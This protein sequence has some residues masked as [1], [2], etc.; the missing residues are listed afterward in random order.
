MY[1]IQGVLNLTFPHR[2]AL[3][4][5]DLLEQHKIRQLV[6]EVGYQ[7]MLLSRAEDLHFAK[8]L[9]DSWRHN[10]CQREGY[11]A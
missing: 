6:M 10:K 8:T 7:S 1:G 4:P 11:L 9:E 3:L 5:H 2:P